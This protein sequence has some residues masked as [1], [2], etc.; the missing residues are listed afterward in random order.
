MGHT[1]TWK[2]GRQLKSFDG[3][4]YTYNA[5]GIRTSKTV[6]GVR[7][8][9]VLDDAKILRETWDGNTLVPLYDNEDS[10]CGIIYNEEPYYFQKNLQGDIIGIVDKDSTVVARYSY[11][12]WGKV[13]SVKNSNNDEITSESHIAIIN[14]FRYRGYYFDQ[15]TNLYYLQSRYYDAEVGRFINGDAAEIITVPEQILQINLFAYCGNNCV[16]ENDIYGNAIGS[17]LYKI[18]MGMMLG[19]LKQMVSDIIN[20]FYESVVLNRGIY[21]KLSPVCDY[22]SSILLEIAAQF[23]VNIK[24]GKA[25]LN[26]IV[27]GAALIVKYIP[28]ILNRKMNGREW[29]NLLGDILSLAII[30][31]IERISEK[32]NKK[33][34]QV[35]KNLKKHPKDLRLNADK[36]ALNLKIKKMGV[37]ISLYIPISQQILSLIAISI[38][39]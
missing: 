36:N 26:L 8:D 3:N 14:P 34:K 27:G 1:L 24:K 25:M 7:H 31:L 29:L 6:D 2:K 33:F 16:N 28:K 9:F 32:V 18:F 5:N 38:L 13:R 37:S 21:V 15:G 30:Y 35:K 39:K 23:T 22:L 11:D 20:L 19:F 17:I 4:T 12:A 10:V